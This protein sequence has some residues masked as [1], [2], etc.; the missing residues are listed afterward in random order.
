[1]HVLE[2][3]LQAVHEQ[4]DGVKLETGF[5]TRSLIHQGGGGGLGSGVTSLQAMLHV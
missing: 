2:L 3:I 1:M 5:L 4:V